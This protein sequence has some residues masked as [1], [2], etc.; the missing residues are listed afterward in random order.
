MADRSPA[1]KLDDTEEQHLVY[2]EVYAPDRPD[3]Q[4]EFMRADEIRKMA[5]EFV[6]SGRMDQIDVMHDNEVVEGCSVVESFI[7]Q[8]DDPTF[9]EGAWVVAVHVPDEKLW[10]SIK[11]GDINGFSMEALVT[12]HKQQVEMEIPAVV[13]GL[14]SKSEEHT[15][16][17]FVS[18]DDS[19]IFKGGVTDVVN[20][21]SH[22]IV[23]GT[24]TEVTKGHSHRF[25][26]VDNVEIL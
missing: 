9:I 13:T 17:F 23:A 10:Q 24:H 1:I 16:K 21:H 20:G 18:Y 14:T 2:G 7:A 26:A 6:R 8:K 3:A 22:N 25:S 5:H 15:H 4:G 19:G 11:N 12:R